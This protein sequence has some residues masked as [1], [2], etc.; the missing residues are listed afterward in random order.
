MKISDPLKNFRRKYI[1]LDL[2]LNASPEK[3]QEDYKRQ[4]ENGDWNI[5]SERAFMENLLCTRFNYFIGVFSLL[6]ATS[7]Q[8]K[9][10][11]TRGIMLFLFAVILTLMG[12]TVYRIYVKLLIILKIIYN[13]EDY[14][15]FHMVNR[16]IKNLRNQL[17]LPVNP[18]IGCIIPFIGICTLWDQT[19][20]F[21]ISLMKLIIKQ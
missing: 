21:C 4:K 18:I 19:Y 8:I 15:V 14:Q 6:M 16:E 7:T 12:L 2:P 3:I 9:V 17:S 20:S 1:T 13:L 5:Y 11:S 10:P